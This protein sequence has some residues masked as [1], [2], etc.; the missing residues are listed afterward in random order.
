MMQDISVGAGI[1]ALD[2]RYTSSGDEV[3]RVSL[4]QVVLSEMVDVMSTRVEIQLV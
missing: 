1:P 2:T 3:L 4:Q